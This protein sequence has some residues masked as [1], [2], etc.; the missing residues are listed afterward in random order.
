MS[1]FENATG[2]WNM[3]ERN[4]KANKFINKKKNQK[5]DLKNAQVYLI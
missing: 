1:D 4:Q 2:L 5:N 3:S